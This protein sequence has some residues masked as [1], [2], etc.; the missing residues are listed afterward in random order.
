MRVQRG[1]TLI[2]LMIVIAIIG[3]L[4]ALAIPA[5]QDYV[6][7]AQVAEGLSLATGAKAAVWDFFSGHGTP[8]ANNASVGLPSPAS[9]RGNYVTSVAVANGVITTTYGNQANAQINGGTLSLSPTTTAG[10]IIW[11]CRG[12]GS[13]LRARY[14][15]SVCR[16]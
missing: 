4:A 15:P 3:I 10:S 13:K 9:I 8:P 14:L 2:E 1:F 16:N 5:Y 7:R 12:D 11:T 6:I